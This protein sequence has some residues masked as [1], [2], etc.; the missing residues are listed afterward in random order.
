VNNTEPYFSTPL[1]TKPFEV[2]VNGY[3]QD[4]PLPPLKDDEGHSAYVSSY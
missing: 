4:F 2:K 1:Q 3:W